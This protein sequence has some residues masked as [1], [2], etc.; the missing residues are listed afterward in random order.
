MTD[1]PSY[2]TVRIEPN[3]AKA[4]FRSGARPLDDYFARYAI[5]NDREGLDAS[6]ST[7]EL[8]AGAWANRCS[9]TRC[10]GSSTRRHRR[11]YW[12]HRRCEGRGRGAVLRE[13]RLRYGARREVAP[14]HVPADWDCEGGVRPCRRLSG[15]NAQRWP[16][17]PHPEH[18]VPLHVIS[19][20]NDRPVIL[21]LDWMT[22]QHLRPLVDC[23]RCGEHSSINCRI[24]GK[25][26]CPR[27]Y[28]EA[29]NL[30]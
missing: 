27:C 15:I 19:G 14:A 21:A 30:L 3:D 2:A 23:S 11:V 9:S 16:V 5:S 18:D 4:G 25:P 8:G 28:P 26:I 6:P 7:T 12:R 20:T 13:V 22:Q 10:I 1:A 24:E 29:L 17:T